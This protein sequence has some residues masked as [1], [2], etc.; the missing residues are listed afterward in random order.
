MMPATK[1]AACSGRCRAALSRRQRE[2][3]RRSDVAEVRSL[4][5]VALRESWRRSADDPADLPTGTVP[6]IVAGVA[7]WWLCVAALLLAGCS[8][9]MMF[10]K[11]GVSEEEYAR[12]R[13]ACMRESR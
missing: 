4:L 2:E 1:R 8:Q 3:A 10:S 6:P 7:R 13:Y 12:D 11:P 5:K 9:T